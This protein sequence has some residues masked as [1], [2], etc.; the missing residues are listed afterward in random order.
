ML[1]EQVCRLVDNL[2]FT[3]KCWVQFLNL[4]TITESV[5]A[6]KIKGMLVDSHIFFFL[7]YANPLAQR[8]QMD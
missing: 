7:H 4:G 1:K 8:I 2:I 6:A 5:E 3:I